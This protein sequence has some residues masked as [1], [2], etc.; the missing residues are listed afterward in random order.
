[1]VAEKESDKVL[2]SILIPVRNAEEFLVQ[3]LSSIAR[4]MEAGKGPHPNSVE[5]LVLNDGSTDKTEALLNQ[6]ASELS[7]VRLLPHHESTLGVSETRNDLLAASRG[8][9]IWFVDADDLVETEALIQFWKI[10]ETSD[11]DII[12]TDFQVFPS[13]EPSRGASR[14]HS[15]PMKK[16]G[17]FN[18]KSVALDALFDVGHFQLWSKVHK[19]SLYLGERVFP[20]NRIFE[21]VVATT[22][23]T[24]RAK[25]FYY[26]ANVWISYRRH[27]QSLV[28][29]LS[30][31]REIDRVFAMFE[32]ARVLYSAKTAYDVRSRF[33]FFAAKHLE[34]SFRLLAGWKNNEQAQSAILDVLSLERSGP[35]SFYGRVVTSLLT[36]GHAIRL[37]RFVRARRAMMRKWK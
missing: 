26:D 9:Y 31:S 27:E 21:D 8:R 22:I 1:M 10:I 16:S 34:K 17:S 12:F 33:H 37:A 30:L 11:P 19:R 3:C 14:K 36:H 35:P 18:S 28:S 2:L 32:T 25:Q 23:L 4:S 24:L 29:Q 13:R 5:V 15:F 7:S 6:A 20:T